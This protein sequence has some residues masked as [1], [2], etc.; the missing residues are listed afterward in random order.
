MVVGKLRMAGCFN[1]WIGHLVVW[2][3]GR[4]ADVEGFRF[5]KK[6]DPL[7]NAVVGVLIYLRRSVP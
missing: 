2:S 5:E 1:L 3:R 6:K 7:R 4:V